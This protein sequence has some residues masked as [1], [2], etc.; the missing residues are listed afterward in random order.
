MAAHAHFSIRTKLRPDSQH[1]NHCNEF[2]IYGADTQHLAIRF[3]DY[4]TCITL[5]AP[6]EHTSIPLFFLYCYADN[7]KYALR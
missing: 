4:T 5:H 6:D 3:I 1:A 7:G 2:G